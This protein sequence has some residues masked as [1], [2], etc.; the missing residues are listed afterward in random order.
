MTTTDSNRLNDAAF[1]PRQVTRPDPRLMKYYFYSSFLAGPLFPVALLPLYFKYHTL[2]YKF[3]DEGDSMRWGILFRR[4]VFLTYRRIQDI[5]LT[6][7]LFQRWLGLATVSVQT[8]S[9]S[10]M[11]EMM[12]EGIPQAEELRDFFYSHMQGGHSSDRPRTEASAM[13]RVETA[14]DAQI[15]APGDEEN[16]GAGRE[17][18]T[19]LLR[20][21]RDQL[22]RAADRMEKAS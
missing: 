19:V 21:I 6:R 3:D 9:G 16:T 2:E 7:N 1:D 8:A 13:R 14:T 4:E 11:P 15:V 12:I 17:E 18:V 10:A 22:Q 20:E 5:H